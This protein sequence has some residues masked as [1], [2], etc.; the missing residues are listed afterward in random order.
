M[1]SAAVQAKNYGQFGREAV[2]GTPVAPTKRIPYLSQ[3]LEA[4]ITKEEDPSYNGGQAAND[5]LSYTEHCQGPIEWQM[6]YDH[7]LWLI[8]WLCGTQTYGAN[9]GTSFGP[10]PYTHTWYLRELH[11]SMVHEFSDGDIPAGKV[12]RGIGLKPTMFYMRGN[13]E[14]TDSIMKLGCNVVGKEYQ[15]NQTPGATLTVSPRTFIRMGHLA[16]LFDDGVGESD[17]DTRLR[18]I[19]FTVE[20]L[21]DKRFNAGSNF[22]DEPWRNGRPKARLRLVRERRSSA[23]QDLYKAGTNSGI[24]LTFVGSASLNLILTINNAKVESYKQ[25]RDG[26]GLQLE[27]LTWACLE[28]GGT[29]S[30]PFVLSVKNNQATISATT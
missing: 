12:G 24:V 29:P 7:M 10:G 30:S 14:G 19:D 9:G 1:G 21:N 8:D 16:S 11:N 25:R 3:D 18:E 5:L 2:W 26:Y 27:E 22:T 4:V 13:S 6:S 20:G 28:D 23:A 15:T 17:A